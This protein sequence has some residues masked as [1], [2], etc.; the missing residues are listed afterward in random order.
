MRYEDKPSSNPEPW[1][2]FHNKVYLGR[3]AEENN[4]KIK[5][6][7]EDMAPPAKQF[8]GPRRIGPGV[9]LRR[10]QERTR[11]VIEVLERE[12]VWRSDQCIQDVY[13]QE[14]ATGRGSSNVLKLRTIAID[15]L[16]K[17]RK[18]SVWDRL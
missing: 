4:A 6:I 12:R 3:V 8:D 1:A 5:G 7:C 15:Q 11:E 10:C 18:K 9:P 14:F 13:I 2:D 16:V 17:F